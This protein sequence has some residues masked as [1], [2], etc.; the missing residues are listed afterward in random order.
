MTSSCLRVS[1]ALDLTAWGIGCTSA[2]ITGSYQVFGTWSAN[3]NGTYIDNT[4]TVGDEQ[5]QL[6]AACLKVSGTTTMCEQLGN[7]FAAVR[8]SPAACSDAVGG[9]CTC[10]VTIK[11]AGGLGVVTV[12][13]YLGGE[14]ATSGNVVTLDSQATYSYC[15]SGDTMTWMP[16]TMGPTV[17]GAI[18]F[19]R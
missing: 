18:V 16:Q 7:L 19:H 2:P 17:T 3:V 12:D 8:G 13:P 14:Y 10:S 6:A 1:G 5:I 9:G 4:V 15:V 11:Q